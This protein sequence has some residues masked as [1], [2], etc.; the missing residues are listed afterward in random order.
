MQVPDGPAAFKVH[1]ATPAG[2]AE[3]TLLPE[4]IAVLSQQPCTRGQLLAVPVNLTLQLTATDTPQQQ[5]Q[6]E[7]D[8]GQ[9]QQQQQ[10]GHAS[11]MLR[12]ASAPAHKAPRNAPQLQRHSQQG[13]PNMLRR[14]SAPVEASAAAAAAAAAGAGQEYLPALDR[15]RPGSQ[16]GLTWADQQQQQQQ[17]QEEGN[18]DADDATPQR[19]SSGSGGGGGG[20]DVGQSSSPSSSSIQRSTSATTVAPSFAPTVAPAAVAAAGVGGV[21]GAGG[22]KGAPQLHHS[23]STPQLGELERLLSLDTA[24][25]FDSCDE[26][27]LVGA[28]VAFE[29]DVQQQQQ[30]QH[31]SR[32]GGMRSRH[33]AQAGA[34]SLSGGSWYEH[35]TGLPDPHAPQSRNEVSEGPQLTNTAVGGDAAGNRA[36]QQQQQQGAA[37]LGGGFPGIFRQ[38]SISGQLAFAAEFHAVLH[39]R[40]LLDAE[41][42][43]SSV[44]SSDGTSGVTGSTRGPLGGA[45]L[46]QGVSPF[47]A[48]GAAAGLETSTSLS[49]LLPDGQGLQTQLTSQHAIN[50]APSVLL[51]GQSQGFGPFAQQQQQLQTAAAMAT[52][53]LC[54]LALLLQSSTAAS[55]LVTCAAF[56]NVACMALLLRPAWFRGVGR[57]LRRRL[58]Q[59]Q[60]Q[61][62]HSSHLHSH[63]HHHTGHHHTGH[64]H[65]NSS[66][67]HRTHHG[68]K[69]QQQQ[70]QQHSKG[71]SGAG[72][73][74]SKHSSSHLQG[75]HS[76]SSSPDSTARGDNSSGNSSSGGGGGLQAQQKLHGLRLQLLGGSYVKE[77]LGLLEQQINAYRHMHE[78]RDSSCSGGLQFCIPEIAFSPAHDAAAAAAAISAS[79]Q[80]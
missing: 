13:V 45:L 80:V 49:M 7:Q 41:D 5:Q 40:L 38:Q 46:S 70:Q 43:T 18:E 51:L 48:A 30:Q 4:L 6:Q 28:D 69:W 55:L 12:R 77:A 34:P 56:L 68:S 62:Q 42:G 15:G 32:G 78:L 10:A 27:D 67:Q 9:Q 72:A 11:G 20:G 53:V 24:V 57:S 71:S 58:R 8:T 2:L 25:E 39:V 54:A 66:G 31:D 47:A 76:S 73:G 60:L 36:D 33:D 74:P 16:K 19:K 44:L 64:H 22:V 61:A 63:H 50:Q 23:R 1:L 35:P 75:Q 21:G 17:Q 29:Q 26:A 3:A 79:N 65:R 14:A 59:Q 52:V 37:A